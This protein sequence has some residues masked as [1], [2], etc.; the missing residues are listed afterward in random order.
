MAFRLV[1]FYGGEAAGFLDA[2]SVHRR[3][4]R[5]GRP[6]CAAR[7]K[8]PGLRKAWKLD[9]IIVNG[10]NAAGGF[11]I[12]EQILNDFLERRRRLRDARQSCLRS[13]RSAE[14][15]HPSAAP[16]PAAQYPKGT[17]GRGASLIETQDGARILIVNALGRMFMDA[18]DDPFALVGGMSR[19]LSAQRSLRCRR[20]RFSCRDDER[21]AGFRAFLRRPGLA[22]R[23][24]AYACADGRSSDPVPGTGY[25]DRCR[26]DGRL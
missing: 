17:P 18:M 22:R 6:H 12:T 8:L 25:H 16:D 2:A 24:L 14:L 21:E 1:T 7:R 5:P 26:H 4:R 19:R 13:K 3:C 15:H 23:R 9:C 11:G 20:H 10:E